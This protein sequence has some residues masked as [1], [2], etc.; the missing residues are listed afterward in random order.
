MAINSKTSASTAQSKCLIY[1]RA[2]VEMIKIKIFFRNMPARDRVRC[3][4]LAVG[5]YLDLWLTL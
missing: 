4:L 3:F 5:V 2:L 1:S